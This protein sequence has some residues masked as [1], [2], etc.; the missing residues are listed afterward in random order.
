MTRLSPFARQIS[1]FLIVGTIAAIFHYG[2]LIGL[3]EG[4]G[5][6]FIPATLAG[7]LGG[8]L[9]SYLLNRRHTFTDS[10]RS[11][12]QASWRFFVVASIGFGLTF[13]FGYLFVNRL[14]A[15]YLPAQMVTTCIVL[16]WNYLANRLWT[17]KI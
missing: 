9:V 7:F 10:T 14:G 2:L 5:W 6:D 3:K 17:F 8:A 12:S 16:V 15:P 13:I 1:A 11:H 4:Q